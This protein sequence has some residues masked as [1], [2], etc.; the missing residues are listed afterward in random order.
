MVGDAKGYDARMRFHVFTPPSNNTQLKPSQNI[1]LICTALGL[2][3]VARAMMN[4]EAVANAL[5]L[6]ENIVLELN[7]PIGY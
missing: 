2:K 5:G 7:H 6:D 4:K 3:T 1:Y